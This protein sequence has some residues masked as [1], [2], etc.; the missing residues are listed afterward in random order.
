MSRYAALRG[1]SDEDA[2]KV[3]RAVFDRREKTTYDS[4]TDA[5]LTLTSVTESNLEA[6]IGRALCLQSF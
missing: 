2:K 6:M 5:I 4:V 1:L 3:L